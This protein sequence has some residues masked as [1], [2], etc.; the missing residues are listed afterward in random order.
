MDL[1]DGV[2]RRSVIKSN[3]CTT[4]LPGNNGIPVRTSA[5]MH[6][7]LQISIAGVYCTQ[8]LNSVHED[9]KKWKILPRALYTHHNKSIL[10]TMKRKIL[11]SEQPYQHTGGH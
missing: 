1:S 8:K 11:W 5:N 7:I 3:W 9:G 10:T 6:P 2:P 4:F